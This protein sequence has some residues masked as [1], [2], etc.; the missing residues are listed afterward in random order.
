M[1]ASR[2]AEHR[3]DITARNRRK[4]AA[5]ANAELEQGPAAHGRSGPGHG[6]RQA[7]IGSSRRF[8]HR[9]ELRTPLN[10]II[11]FT[12]ILLQGLA[13]TLNEEQQKQMRMVQSSSRHLLAL[14]NDVL[15]M[16]KI[17]A[18]QLMLAPA[19]FDLRAAIE[20]SVQVVLPMAD[21]RHRR[22]MEMPPMWPR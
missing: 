18:G 4:S 9:H 11:G 7:A 13:G 21:K 15:D 19:A 2:R 12:G 16:S 5:P 10:S 6:A 3:S 14:I 17:E 20:K 8:Y 1:A 22:N